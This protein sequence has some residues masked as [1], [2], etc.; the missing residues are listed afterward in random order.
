[1][2]SL[3]L[4]LALAGVSIGL[5]VLLP[6][7]SQAQYPTY[8]YPT[9]QY[10]TYQYP[11]YQYPTYQYYYSGYSPYPY[12]AYTVTTVPSYTNLQPYT[13]PRYTNAQ[14]STVPGFTYPLSVNRISASSPS[15]YNVSATPGYP[16][17]YAGTT[18]NRS[19]YNLSATPGYSAATYSTM[20]FQG[21]TL[22]RAPAYYGTYNYR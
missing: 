13:V 4:F 3:L 14:P 16:V 9:Y 19:Y 2:R 12:T 8:Q 6:A 7:Q 11:T 17:G 1:M 18:V 20:P 10:P 21:Y 22:G 5:M 15:Y